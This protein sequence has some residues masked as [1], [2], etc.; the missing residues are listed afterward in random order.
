MLLIDKILIHI[1]LAFI[2][3]IWMSFLNGDAQ[4]LKHMKRMRQASGM[5]TDYSRWREIMTALMILFSWLVLI[6][7]VYRAWTVPDFPV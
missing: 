1:G 7:Y 6:W 3:L 4:F 2:W 5:S